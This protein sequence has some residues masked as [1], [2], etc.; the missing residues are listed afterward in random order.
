MPLTAEQATFISRLTL[1][2]LKNEHQITMRV[3]EAIPPG[4]GNYRPD[5]VGRSALDLAWHIVAAENHFLDGVATGA[6]H[7]GRGARPD[8]MRDSADIAAWYAETFASNA[9]RLKQLP[10][11]D[12]LRTLDYRGVFQLPAFAYLTFAVNHSIH[13]RGQLSTYLRP[14]GAKVPSIYGESYDAVQDRLRG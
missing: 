10:G 14:M 13:H 1:P 8:G 12:L 6:F 4:K 11:E 7:D 3:I 5:D 2:T 9:E